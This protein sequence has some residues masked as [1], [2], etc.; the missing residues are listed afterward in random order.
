MLFARPTHTLLTTT[1]LALVSLFT[2]SAHAD[3]QVRRSSVYDRQQDTVSEKRYSRV[4]KSL[5]ILRSSTAAMA[6]A[7]GGSASA[8]GAV[9]L[10]GRVIAEKGEK[11]DTGLQGVK[12]D[13]GDIGEKGI[14]GDKGDKGER[15]EQGVAGATGAVGPR[16][17]VGPTG[18]MPSARYFVQESSCET[19]DIGTLCGEDLGPGCEVLMTFFS[20]T[21]TRVLGHQVNVVMHPR[22]QSNSASRYVTFFAPTGGSYGE[23]YLGKAGATSNFFVPHKVA[24]FQNHKSSC[25]SGYAAPAQV[26][27]AT[28][29]AYRDT[30]K[31]TLRTTAGWNVAIK[32]VKR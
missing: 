9:V 1:A 24:V 3:N 25:P 22:L 32:I 5:R 27:T 10:P 21:T 30:G 16:G 4:D 26:G 14:K 7:L 19:I 13:K 17:P 23:G 29:D 12:G 15:G 2:V 28:N 18:E 11:G 8:T 6:K 31:L 20:T